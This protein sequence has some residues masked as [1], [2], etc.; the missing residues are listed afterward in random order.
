MRAPFWA[1]DIVCVDDMPFLMGATGR[2][3]GATRQRLAPEAH[4]KHLVEVI[5]LKTGS[6]TRRGNWMLSKR[7]H[8]AARLRS[9]ENH[10]PLKAPRISTPASSGCLSYLLSGSRRTTAA[11]MFH[12]GPRSGAPQS[13]PGPADSWRETA[14]AC[15]VSLLGREPE[16]SNGR[17]REPPNWPS[18]LN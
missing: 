5:A 2:R 15:P 13:A 12:V 14:R 11:R 1:G 9:P 6:T 7:S 18:F 8:D 17:R 16:R 10:T 3:S 4:Q